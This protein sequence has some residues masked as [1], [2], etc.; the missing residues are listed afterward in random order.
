ML[1]HQVKKITKKR[2]DGETVLNLF[3]VI[4]T[5]VIMFALV[6]LFS[7]W[8]RNVDTK[9]NVD[10][11]CRKYMLKMETQGYLTSDMEKDLKAE[12]EAAGVVGTINFT[13][14]KN[15]VTYKTT[16]T[17][18]KYGDQIYL[19]LEF[20]IKANTPRL[21]NADEAKNNF[22]E[23]VSGTDGTIHYSVL[24][25]TTSKKNGK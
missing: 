2:D 18:Q 10:Q 23:V 5:S 14:T 13:T 24:R 19:A 6:M 7:S 8:I 21:K 15:G 22:M 11:V 9:D 16:T 1:K 4:L 12:L 3:P 20:D 17:E 25:G